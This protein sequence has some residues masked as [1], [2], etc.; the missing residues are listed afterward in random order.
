MKNNIKRIVLMIIAIVSFI[1][2]LIMAVLAKAVIEVFGD[3]VAAG[4]NQTFL[5]I[6]VPFGFFQATIIASG[7]LVAIGIF[8]IKKMRQI[9]KEE[10]ACSCE[11]GD[12]N[13]NNN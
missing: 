10:T 12:Y 7:V 4:L 8:C 6:A 1:E 13:F 2:A 11:D 3:N 5:S 9:H